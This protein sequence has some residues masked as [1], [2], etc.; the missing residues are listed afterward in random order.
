MYKQLFGLLWFQ[1]IFINS[2]QGLEPSIYVNNAKLKILKL[3]TSVGIELCKSPCQ[4]GVRIGLYTLSSR[5]DL[6]MGCHITKGV[7]QQCT[8][9]LRLTSPGWIE[10]KILLLEHVN[11]FA[12]KKILTKVM[13]GI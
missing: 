5:Q 12:T 3:L 7:T 1:I 4:C 13:T 10:Q 11:S 2:I 6:R 8:V 9:R